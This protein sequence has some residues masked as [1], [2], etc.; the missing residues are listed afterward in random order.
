M[1]RKGR[2]N[3]YHTHERYEFP[4][5]P[6][7]IEH[8]QAP[9]AGRRDFLRGA[10]LAVGGTLLAA[11]APASA[12]SEGA[13]ASATAPVAASAAARALTE[14]EKLARLAS[15]TYPLRTLFK[16]RPSPGG[17]GRP[18]DARAGGAGRRA[19]RRD[20]EEVR[21]DHAARLP[22]VHEGPLPRRPQDGPVVVALRRRR[23]RRDVRQERR[24]PSTARARTNREFDPST[25]A[26]KKW[27]DQLT[28]RM[29][30]TGVSCHHV[31]NNAPRNI[32]DLD[33]AARAAGIDIAKT[34]L[35]ACATHRRQDHAGQHR[36]PA[37][38]SRRERDD[39]AIRATTRWSSTSATPSSRSRR[40]PTTAARSAS[41]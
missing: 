3:S 25:A 36:R 32:S 2:R 35:D 37:H 20:E 1:K 15:N 41:R 28:D 8:A 9:G 7:S 11:A 33:A 26:S 38:R 22:A 23:R 21:R 12:A 30:T 14:H 16:R 5:H 24:S 39:A 31:S 10:G 4:H 13:P 27:L 17:G 19:W 29:A 34:W 40:W 6:P 18:P